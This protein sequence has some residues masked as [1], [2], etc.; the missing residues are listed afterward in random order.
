MS[1]HSKWASIKHKKAATDSQRGKIFSKLI[2]EIT[3]AVRNGGSK[4]ESNARLRMV[5]DKA[6]GC[7]M[8]AD[9]IKRAIQRGTGELP[10]MIIEE[11]TYEGYGPAGI[12][13]LVEAITDNKNRITA[14]IRKIFSRSGGNM[15]ESGCV[16]WMFGKKGCISIDKNEIG[17]DELLEIVMEAGA[18]DLKLEGDVYEIITQPQ[19]FELVKDAILKKGIKLKFTEI[20][21]IPKNYIKVDAGTARTVLNLIEALEENEDVQNVYSNADIPDEIMQELQQ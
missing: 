6:K 15:G 18:E 13:I 19:D 5:L 16:S 11:T 1:G 17:E 7:N 9:N 12:A 8:P 20:S 4:P 21:M 14:E 3:I 2:H 10:G